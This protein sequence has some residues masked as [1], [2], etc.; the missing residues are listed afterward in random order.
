MPTLDDFQGGEPFADEV[1]RVEKVN[2]VRNPHYEKEKCGFTCRIVNRGDEPLLGYYTARKTDPNLFHKFDSYPIT[3]RI[4]ARLQ[5]EGAERVVVLEK[6]VEA[7]QH[8]VYE[9]TLG[10]YLD[11][12]EYEWER[13]EEGREFVDKQKCASRSDALHVYED[14][15]RHD[16]RPD[17]DAN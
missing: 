10:Q 9:F 8:N 13:V 5:Y 3:T 7:E 17:L 2:R 4:L 6:D 1:P 11:A 16:L 15:S 14:V 12:P